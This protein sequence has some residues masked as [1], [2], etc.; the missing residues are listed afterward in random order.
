MKTA[1][2]YV[3]KRSKLL[4][5]IMC[6]TTTLS[7]AIEASKMELYRKELP[8]V[9]EA[10]RQVRTSGIAHYSGLLLNVKGKRISLTHLHE[11]ARSIE[12]KSKHDLLFLVSYF[13][14]SDYRMR[15]LA[16]WA[17]V[18]LMEMNNIKKIPEFNYTIFL[19]ENKAIFDD[20]VKRILHLIQEIPTFD[21]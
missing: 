16:V 5:L 7:S 19:E 1:E 18:T 10:T 3:L 11:V 2:S 14:D 13:R 20:F 21:K 9:D 15:Y 8:H 6:I 12:I 17:V 4:I